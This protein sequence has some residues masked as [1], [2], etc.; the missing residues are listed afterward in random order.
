MHSPTNDHSI[1]LSDWREGPFPKDQE[2][3]PK[4]KLYEALSKAQAEIKPAVLDMTNP[5]FKS[6]Y[7][8][9]TSILEAIREPLAKN[10]LCVL[11]QVESI[12]ESYWITTILA[13]SSGQEISNSFRLI[14]NK[15]DMQGLGSAITYGR[16]YGISALLGVVDTEDDDG[17]QASIKSNPQP[18][19]SYPQNKPTLNPSNPNSIPKELR[20]PQGVSSGITEHGPKKEL[21]QPQL[22]RLYAISNSKGWSQTD[23]RIYCVATF[24]KTPGDLSRKQYDMLVDHI[25]KNPN[26]PHL[27]M[28]FSEMLNGLKEEQKQMVY[29]KE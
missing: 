13:H 10:N 25:E 21:T 9:L 7:A 14:V 27:D 20:T 28:R 8:S 15:N 4:S 2:K 17:N 18:Q 24:G 1:P 29:R 19:Q 22:K 16:R 6:K 5:H 11:Q 26:G 3:F 12:D 23:C